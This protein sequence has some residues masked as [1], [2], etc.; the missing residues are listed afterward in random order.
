MRK[1]ETLS[2]APKGD[3]RGRTKDGASQDSTNSAKRASRAAAAWDSMEEKAEWEISHLI[4]HLSM[5]PSGAVVR[6]FDEQISRVEM[7]FF[8]RLHIAYLNGSGKGGIGGEN[9]KVEQRVGGAIGQE[10]EFKRRLCADCGQQK[11]RK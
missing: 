2:K 11:R 6:H 8:T 10:L 5:S 1:G 3:A 4:Y 9:G 7:H